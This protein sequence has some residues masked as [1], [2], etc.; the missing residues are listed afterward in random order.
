MF[1]HN[2]KVNVFK[3]TVPVQ[4]REM[5]SYSLRRRIIINDLHASFIRALNLADELWAS[6]VTMFQPDVESLLVALQS[7]RNLE[8]IGKNNQGRLFRSLGNLPTLLWMSVRGDTGS[9]MVFP[10]R[11]LADALSETSNGV[12]RLELSNFTISSRS[13]VERLAFGLKARVG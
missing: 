13:E 5:S 8:T 10:T 11:V 3:Q 4:V 7:N 1:Y 12:R 6:S 9:P 2:V